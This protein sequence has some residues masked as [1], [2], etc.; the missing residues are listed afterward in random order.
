LR[1]VLVL[2]II[3]DAGQSAGTSNGMR[4]VPLPEFFRMK[5]NSFNWDKLYTSKNRKR[6][7]KVTD[8][9]NIWRKKSECSVPVTE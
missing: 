6:S 4:Y 8:Y 3:L 5:I 1:V 2:L 9:I 7:M